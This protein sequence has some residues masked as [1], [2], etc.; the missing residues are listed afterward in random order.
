[1]TSGQFIYDLAE[2]AGVTVGC[3]A[4]TGYEYIKVNYR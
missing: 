3:L 2:M 4:D 1:M